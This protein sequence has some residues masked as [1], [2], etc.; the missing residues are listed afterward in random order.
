MEAGGET[1]RS[2]ARTS[3]KALCQS[4]NLQSSSSIFHGIDHFISIEAYLS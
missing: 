2:M 4:G 1:H 3:L